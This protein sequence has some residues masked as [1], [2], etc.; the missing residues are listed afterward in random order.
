MIISF[1]VLLQT[2]NVYSIFS[3]QPVAI[4]R[5]PAIRTSKHCKIWSS[6]GQLL[7]TNK[8]FAFAC[9]GR[10]ILMRKL[11]NQLNL[12]WL[13]SFS[14][15]N[16]DFLSHWTL[17]KLVGQVTI[18]LQTRNI[19]RT[20]PFRTF[21]H[22]LDGR[23]RAQKNLSTFERILYSRMCWKNYSWWNMGFFVSLLHFF[24]H[25]VFGGVNVSKLARFVATISL[26]SV[27]IFIIFLKN[28]LLIKVLLLRK[29]LRILANHNRNNVD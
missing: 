22:M 27:I 28:L 8:R 21:C 10:T 25:A 29:R 24:M 1:K 11:T 7:S 18:R 3:L 26:D 4:A 16:S 9:A 12:N 14:V 5:E 17:N 13:K 2:G 20:L 15:G 19:R 6:H 23:K